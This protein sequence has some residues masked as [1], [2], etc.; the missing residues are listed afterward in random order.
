VQ[1]ERVKQMLAA[2]EKWNAE[3]VP[4]AWQETVKPRK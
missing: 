3:L 1:P 2:W 4:A